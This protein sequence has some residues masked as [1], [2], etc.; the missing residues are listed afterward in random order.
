MNVKQ[1]HRWLTGA[2]S[3]AMLL[4][5]G[6]SRSPDFDIM[7]SLFPAWLICVALGAALAVAV[8]FILLRYRIQ[9]LYP[10]LAYACMAAVFTFA[11]W[12]IV[13]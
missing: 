13:Y 1:S 4:A 12:L 7:G 2:G 6:C 11:I 10:L 3:I 8:R 5:A 9:L